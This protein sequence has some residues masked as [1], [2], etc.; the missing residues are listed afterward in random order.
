MPRCLG[1][2]KMGMAGS[3]VVSSAE[4]GNTRRQLIRI[5]S[6][7]RKDFS[8]YPARSPGGRGEHDGGRD[9]YADLAAFD[10]DFFLYSEETDFCLRLR[11]AL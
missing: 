8:K 7:V 11:D 2:Q 6:L 4:N 9:I 3:R 5:Q 1:T 10:P